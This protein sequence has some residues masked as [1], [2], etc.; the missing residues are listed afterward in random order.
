MLTRVVSFLLLVLLGTAA[1]AGPPKGLPPRFATVDSI[2]PTL[3][4]L[5]VRLF[6]PNAPTADPAER[7]VRS[8][9]LVL[10]D[11]R[12][13]RADGKELSG[14]QAVKLLIPGKVVFVAEGTQPPEAGWLKPLTGDTLILLVP[15]APGSGAEKAAERRQME[16][17]EQDIEQLKR[18][19]ERP[20]RD[21]EWWEQKLKE[22]ERK[23]RK[24]A[25]PPTVRGVVK[26]DTSDDRLK[27]SGGI[28]AGFR[29]GQTLKV[30]RIDPVPENSVYLGTVRVESVSRDEA[31]ARPLKRMVQPVK[32]GDRVVSRIQLT[33]D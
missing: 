16:R 8:G 18:E 17:L 11:F 6:P 25:E 28:D 12:V 5:R 33:S 15:P 30:F 22:L 4:V 7:G 24:E 10:G 32:P 31:V 26:E 1:P 2:D 21:H 13:V 27:I 3:G 20:K 23:P 19:I 9:F 29:T 14:E